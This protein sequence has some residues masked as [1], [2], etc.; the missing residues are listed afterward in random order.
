[1]KKDMSWTEMR[2]HTKEGLLV[3]I[4]SLMFPLF[5]KAGPPNDS[6][7]GDWTS[8]NST[9]NENVHKL[10]EDVLETSRYIKINNNKNSY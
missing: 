6:K 2:K 3:K 8:S 4:E 9:F 7:G 10:W 1:M 5:W